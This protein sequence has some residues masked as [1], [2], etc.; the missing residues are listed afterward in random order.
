MCIHVLGGLINQLINTLT[1]TGLKLGALTT[2]Q[3]PDYK[4][5]HCISHTVFQKK[6]QTNLSNSVTD[7]RVKLVLCVN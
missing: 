2:I 7:L 6:F 3:N 5:S 4:L 1:Q